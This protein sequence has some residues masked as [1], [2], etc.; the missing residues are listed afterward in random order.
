MKICILTANLGNFD[1]RV[2]PVEQSV[3]ADFYR[4]TDENFPPRYVSMTPRLQARICKTFGWQMVPGY[5]MYIWIDGSISLRHP[6]SVRWLIEK[7]TGDIA[8]F[9]HPNRKTV[10]EEADYLKKR[11]AQKCDY[12]IPRYDNELIDEELEAVSEFPDKYL[13][14]SGALVYKNNEKIHAMMKE[15]WYHISR[16]HSIDQLGLPYALQKTG[17]DFTVIPEHYGKISYLTL[18]KRK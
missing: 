5:D 13:F 12:I 3:P 4:F 6:D 1:E 9:Q 2:D 7:C 16:F 17:C 10:K 11:I 15:W 18:N 8:V 14:A